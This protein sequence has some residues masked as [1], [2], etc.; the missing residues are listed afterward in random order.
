MITINI[1]NDK[2]KTDLCYKLTHTGQYPD[3]NSNVLWNYQ[4]LWI[5][6][7]YCRA[8]IICSSSEK[9][10]FQINNIKSFLS[11]NGYP[12]F[13]RNSIIKQL[14]T[15]PKKVEKE[16]DDRKIIWIQLPYLGNI[17]DNMKKNFLRKCKNVYKK[18]L[19]L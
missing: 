3:I 2:S 16:K 7:F 17:G 15:S 11:W 19:V 5:K 14:K 12:S 8:E 13:T 1:A 18:I 6:S 4:V 9:F 10:R